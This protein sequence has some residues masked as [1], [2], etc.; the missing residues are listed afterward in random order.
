MSVPAQAPPFET[1]TR[2]NCRIELTGPDLYLRNNGWEYFLGE[3]NGPSHPTLDL[4][5]AVT[6]LRLYD[7]KAIIFHEIPER[8][9]SF[10]ITFRV[11][12]VYRVNE[13]GARI[14]K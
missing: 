9:E 4:D 5:D 1:L 12:N 13:N 6:E 8:D 3:E 7:D 14:G 11:R 10:E 2:D